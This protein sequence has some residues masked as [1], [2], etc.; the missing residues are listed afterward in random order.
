MVKSIL[1]V[2]IVLGVSLF[3]SSCATTPTGS[4]NGRTVTHA[5]D[6]DYSDPDWGFV[7]D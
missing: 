7:G 1:S 5:P 6:Y 2:L 3:L 4:S